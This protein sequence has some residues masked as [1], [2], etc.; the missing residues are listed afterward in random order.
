[1]IG[2]GTLVNGA[3]IVAGGLC[4]LFG[5]SRMN[6][7]CRAGL[8]LACGISVLFIGIA[9]AMEKMLTVSNGVIGTGQ[10]MLLTICLALGAF[11]GELEPDKADKAG[12]GVGEVVQRVGSDGNASGKRSSDEF[13]CA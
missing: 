4:G 12:G 2:I 6:E 7:R 11:F 9:G 5:G 13:P 1:M 8:S 3:A 10:S